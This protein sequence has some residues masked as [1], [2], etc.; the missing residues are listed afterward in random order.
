MATARAESLY[1]LHPGYAM[2]ASSRAELKERTGKSLEEWIAFVQK[3]GPPGEK[4]RRDW[5]KRQPAITPNYAWWIAER[6]A[7][8]SDA[9]DYHPEILVYGQLLKLA[10]RQ[11]KDVKVCP[12][13]TI[14]PLYRNHV[15]AQIKPRTRTETKKDRI[16][17]RIVIRSLAD[18]DAEVQRWLR[19]AYELDR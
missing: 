4:D 17:H 9:E 6:A 11:G 2:E 7:G 18:I 19:T 14:V 13:E 3:S 12:C 8:N 5:L 10:L 15:F 16:T 1:S